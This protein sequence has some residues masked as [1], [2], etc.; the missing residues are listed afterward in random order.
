LDFDFF[1]AKS[2]TVSIK[3]ALEWVD[4]AHQEVE[5]IFEGCINERLR[6]IFQELK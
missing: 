1:L 2:Q 6:E 4:N 5:K 3:Q